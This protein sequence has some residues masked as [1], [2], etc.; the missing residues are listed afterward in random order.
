MSNKSFKN[1]RNDLD[2]LKY[3]EKSPRTNYGPHYFPQ[4]IASLFDSGSGNHVSNKEK[5]KYRKHLVSIFPN[6]VIDIINYHGVDQ[7][8]E[9]ACSFVGFLNLS[10]LSG[11]ENKLKKNT[12]KNWKKIWNS[13]GIES[14]ADIGQ[15]LDKIINKKLFINNKI[16]KEN[17]EYIPIRSER[18]RE[19]K[20]NKTFWKTGIDIDII[21]TRYDITRPIYDSVSWTYQN[22][23][24]IETL[25]DSGIP[26][27][28][29]ALEHSRTCIGYNEELLLF[30][31]NWDENYEQT[32]SDGTDNYFKC[33]FSTINKWAIYSWMR[34]IVYYKLSETPKTKMLNT[35]KTKTKLLGRKSKLSRKKLS[36]KKSK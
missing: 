12:I 28:I 20:F 22:A 13:F 8:D 21:L 31:D 23:Y 11:N 32:S 36:N 25:I 35:K 18:N 7:E 5:I 2:L 26:V 16:H 14:A 27:E 3:M 19:M 15:T 1:Q 4:I 10:L 9:G 17:I 29:N 30:A 33:G 24:L 34:D 6:S